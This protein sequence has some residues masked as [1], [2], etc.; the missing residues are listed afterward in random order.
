MAQVQEMESQRGIK[1]QKDFDSETVRI[2]VDG[3][4]VVEI[5][6]ADLPAEIASKLA[7]YG[8]AVKLTR[9]TA[10]KPKEQW[11]EIMQKLAEALKEGKWTVGV[12]GNPKKL[13]VL[14]TIKE[15]EPALREAYVNSLRVA[16]VLERLGITE[17]EVQEAMRA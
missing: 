16:G 9:A 13:A 2:S 1:V 5:S 14:A 7:V 11:A 17:E 10:G 4:P 15:T 6:V 8:L 3:N 12:F